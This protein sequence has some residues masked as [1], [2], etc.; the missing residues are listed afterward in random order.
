LE[1]EYA[2][3]E[4]CEEDGDAVGYVCISLS[5]IVG[6]DLKV[7]KIEDISVRV[8][9]QRRGIGSL[10]LVHAEAVAHERGAHLLRADVGVSNVG[11]RALHEKAGFEPFRIYYEKRLQAP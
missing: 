7:A 6:Y 11:S 9:R 8:D 10:M 3:V 4:V 1:D 5:D 2:L